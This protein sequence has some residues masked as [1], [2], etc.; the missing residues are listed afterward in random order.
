MIAQHNIVNYT[1][2]FTKYVDIIIRIKNGEMSRKYILI[3]INVEVD[4]FC[5]NKLYCKTKIE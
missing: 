3:A 5:F 1:L 4:F 2:V